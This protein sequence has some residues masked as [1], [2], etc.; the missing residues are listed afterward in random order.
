MN[1]PKCGHALSDRA[2]LC[3]YCGADFGS[4]PGR[5]IMFCRECGARLP[6]GSKFCTNCGTPVDGKERPKT[7][8]T[9]SQPETISE[10][11]YDIA[12]KKYKIGILVF[13]IGEVVSAIILLTVSNAR[14]FLPKLGIAVLITL[15]AACFMGYQMYLAF[16]DLKQIEEKLIP[17]EKR[18]KFEAFAQNKLLTIAPTFIDLLALIYVALKVV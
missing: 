5:S 11:K 13:W 1:C 6:D 9:T 7:N 14:D 18:L 16:K 4:V 10:V 12:T 17:Q 2:T 8:S 3:P 15:V